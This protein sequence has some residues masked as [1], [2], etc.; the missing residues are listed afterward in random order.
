MTVV[1]DLR[2]EERTQKLRSEMKN[3]V[4]AMTPDERIE[5]FTLVEKACEGYI[6]KGKQ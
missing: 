6:K 5:Y 1:E 2:Q 4:N 3:M